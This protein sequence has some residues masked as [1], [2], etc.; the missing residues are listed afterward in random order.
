[1]RRQSASWGLGAVTDVADVQQ[2]AY[3]SIPISGHQWHQ[4]LRE[5]PKSG[6]DRREN[7]ANLSSTH[8]PDHW[9]CHHPPVTVKKCLEIPWEIAIFLGKSS[10]NRWLWQV[11][12]GFGRA[13]RWLPR[14]LR[15]L[16]TILCW[17][18]QEWEV[19]TDFFTH[20][21]YFMS[22]LFLPAATIG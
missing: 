18:Q 9:I 8:W 7:W 20:Y 6:S 16:G 21:F 19:W 11:D 1:M 3:H 17:F 10:M 4:C 2:F 13:A 15:W 12:G 22:F 5:G 14:W